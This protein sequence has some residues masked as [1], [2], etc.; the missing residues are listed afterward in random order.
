MQVEDFE[1]REPRGDDGEIGVGDAWIKG[2]GSGLGE[3][4]FENPR[5]AVGHAAEHRGPGPRAEAPPLGALK[6]EPPPADEPEHVLL[7]LPLQLREDE[8]E[9]VV[10]QRFVDARRGRGGA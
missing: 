6:S 7:L 8:A 1:C 3:V 2:S 10:G 4:Q 5:E 9:L